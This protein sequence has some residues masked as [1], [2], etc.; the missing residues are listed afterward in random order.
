MSRNGHAAAAVECLRQ[1]ATK[2]RFQDHSQQG[3]V[4]QFRLIFLASRE[5]ENER[6]RK[7]TSLNGAFISRSILFN[8]NHHRLSI[9]NEL[10]KTNSKEVI[11]KE[12]RSGESENCA[13]YSTPSSPLR[14]FQFIVVVVVDIFLSISIKC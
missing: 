14:R 7:R 11:M 2:K 8:C 4:E 1:F 10:N 9:C 3:N 12:L 5:K 13:F 6:E